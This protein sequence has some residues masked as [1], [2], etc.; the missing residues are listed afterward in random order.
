[1]DQGRSAG[2]AIALGLGSLLHRWYIPGLLVYLAVLLFRLDQAPLLNPDEAAYTEPAWTLLTEGRFGAPMY[3]GLLSI[4]QRWY[5]LWPGY[6][7]LALMPYAARGVD[8]LAVRLLSGAFGGLLLV[9][10]WWLSRQTAEPRGAAYQDRW[11]AVAWMLVAAH[12]T[13]FFLSRFGRPEIA[14]AALAVLSS[15]LGARAWC[16]P[17]PIVHSQ[18]RK[19]IW[20][21]DVAAGAAAGLSCLMHQYGALA[22]LALAAAYLVRPVRQ[23]RATAGKLL[24]AGLGLACP[25]LPWVLWLVFDWNEFSAQFGAQLQYQ[26]W[27]YPQA[28]LLQSLLYD[29]PARYVLSVQDYA[30][31][32]NPWREALVNLLGPRATGMSGG[33]PEGT[34]P[35]LIRR[36]AYVAQYWLQ[37]GPAVPARWLALGALV[38]ALSA[39]ARSAARRSTQNDTLLRWVIVPLV[40]WVLGLAAIPNKWHGYTGAVAAYTTVAI[41]ALLARTSSPLSGPERTDEHG[42]SYSRGH[43]RAA[44]HGLPRSLLAVVVA[45]GVVFWIL[46]DALSLLRPPTRYATFAARLHEVVPAGEPVACTM[47]EWFAFAGRNPAVTVEFRSIPA[48]HTSLL[49]MLADERPH[50]LVLHRATTGAGS[51]G[52]ADS[53][54]PVDAAEAGEAIKQTRQRYYFIYPPWER[55]YAYL[56]RSTT[57]VATIQDVSFGTVEVRRVLEWPD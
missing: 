29:L 54:E 49:E 50:Y 9:A 28:T 45:V 38:L 11:A 1:M 39:A 34:A 44:L 12:P 15:A 47:R 22:V 37:S 40:V 19:R 8:V 55:F 30:P 17:V 52:A 3:R 18:A 48:F 43:L 42:S 23:L 5:F 21:W 33:V 25:L 7:V 24:L 4:D 27:R 26:R 56:D 13:V 31:G 14:V 35:S 16:S 2:K 51:D 36:A 32:W 53:G 6:G 41:V 20:I 57:L 46:D 10:A